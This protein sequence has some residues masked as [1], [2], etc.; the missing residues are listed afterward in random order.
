MSS[1]A[2]VS[3]GIPCVFIA[4]SNCERKFWYDGEEYFYGYDCLIYNFFLSRSLHSRWQSCLIIVGGKNLKIDSTRILKVLCDTIDY[5]D[6]ITVVSFSWEVH[7]LSPFYLHLSLEGTFCPGPRLQ[8]TYLQTYTSLR[9]LHRTRRA[10]LLLVHW[11]LCRF[12]VDLFY[13]LSF[14]F[15]RECRLVSWRN[16]RKNPNIPNLRD[17][18]TGI[19]PLFEP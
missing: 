13:L 16:D 14:L 19:G 2:V 9:V 1:Y 5:K 8:A 4:F 7:N 10:A 17:N 12:F 15:R 3:R 11:P 18:R 6:I